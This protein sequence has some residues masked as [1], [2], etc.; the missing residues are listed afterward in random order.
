MT[1]DRLLSGLKHEE[2]TSE[3][4]G[5]RIFVIVHRRRILE[6]GLKF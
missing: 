3:R 6:R 2:E 4:A 1:E 5:H